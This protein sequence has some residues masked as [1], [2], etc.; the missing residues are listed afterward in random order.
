MVDDVCE[1]AGVLPH[2]HAAAAAAAVAA[3]GAAL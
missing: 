1:L 2:S 3:R